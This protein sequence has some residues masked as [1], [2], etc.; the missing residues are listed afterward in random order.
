MAL[1][2]SKGGA[3]PGS[4]R[5]TMRRGANKRLATD[6]VRPLHQRTATFVAVTR[7]EQYLAFR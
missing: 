4:G 2:M 1:R 3:C 6:Y 5:I 7:M